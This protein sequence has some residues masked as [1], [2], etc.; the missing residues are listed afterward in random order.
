MARSIR[1]KRRKRGK[2]RKVTSD[3]PK[4]AFFSKKHN[5]KERSKLY[6]FQVDATLIAD[7]FYG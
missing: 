2:H 1:R 3:R 4:K 5:C 6:H 7:S